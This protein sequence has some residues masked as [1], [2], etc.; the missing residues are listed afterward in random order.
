MAFDMKWI[1]RELQELRRRITQRPLDIVQR[2]IP[3][4]MTILIDVGNTLETGQDGIVYE[5]SIAEVPSAYD[6]NV[7][8]SFIDGIGRGTLFKN[9]SAQSGYVLVINTDQGSFRN[10]LLEG[11]VVWTSGAVEVPVDGGGTVLAYT[12]G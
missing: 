12:V 10:A 4:Y 11:D 5:A 2:T 6:P 9:G 8:S 3:D 7:T 1:I